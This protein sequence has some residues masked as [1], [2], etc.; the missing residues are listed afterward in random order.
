MDEPNGGTDRPA[1]RSDADRFEA[2]W[3]QYFGNRVLPGSA[4]DLV[5]EAREIRRVQLKDVV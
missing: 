3:E 4:V 2:L 1:Y 5:R